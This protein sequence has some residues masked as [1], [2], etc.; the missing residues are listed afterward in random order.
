MSRERIRGKK[1][2]KRKPSLI[3]LAGKEARKRNEVKKKGRLKEE[4]RKKAKKIQKQR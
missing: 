3:L 2:V 4:R 1:W